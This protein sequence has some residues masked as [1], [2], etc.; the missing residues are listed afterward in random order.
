MLFHQDGAHFKQVLSLVLFNHRELLPST[1][2]SYRFLGPI[3]WPTLFMQ[4]TPLP[5][6]SCL[7]TLPLNR[8]PMFCLAHALPVSSRGCALAWSHLLL[9]WHDFLLLPPRTLFTPLS[10]FRPVS[11]IV[12]FTHLLAFSFLYPKA[13]FLALVFLGWPCGEPDAKP[14]NQSQEASF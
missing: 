6:T 7:L 13:T 11:G 14:G 9:A 12:L 8:P 10:P 1:L 5:I 3:L 4:T 2:S